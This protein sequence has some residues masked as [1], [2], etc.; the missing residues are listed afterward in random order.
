MICP[1]EGLPASAPKP[2]TNSTVPNLD[3]FIDG[4]LAG[5]WESST[6]ECEPIYNRWL[7]ESSE[8][9]KWGSSSASTIMALLPTLMTLTSVITAD[10]G[11]LCHLSTTQGFIAAAFTFGLP[12]RQQKT[13]KFLKTT[14]VRDLLQVLEFRDDKVLSLRPFSEVADKLLHEI[15]DTALQPELRPRRIWV[16]FLRLSFGYVQAMLIWV[17]LIYVPGIDSFYLI[18]LCPNWGSVVFSLWL[19]TTFTIVG[20]WRARFERNAFKGDEVIYISEINTSISIWKRVLDPHPMILILC[21]SDDLRKDRQH[22]HYFGGMLQL[23]WIGFLSFLFSSTIGGSLFSTLLMVFVFIAVV[24]V[25][26]GLSIVVCCLT[27]KYL[28][29]RVIEY[30]SIE[31]RK[32]IQRLIGGLTGVLLD[33]QCVNYK[34]ETQWD[35]SL[36]MYKWGDQASCGKEMGAPDDNKQCCAHIKPQLRDAFMSSF[37]RVVAVTVLAY[38]V[39]AFP[40]RVMWGEPSELTSVRVQLGAGMIITLASTIS[41]LHLGLRRQWLICKCQDEKLGWPVKVRN[42]L[43]SV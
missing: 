11:L 38:W 40:N 28:D 18:W 12:F 22:T 16:L 31:E 24:G 42:A 25:S 37:Y 9:N 33:I 7:E 8:F 23:F 39:I 20:W 14:K 32:S 5:L 26:R 2:S 3:Q 41:C 30:D 1:V 27:N 36:K 4:P 13:R 21:P 15:R 6:W 17:L 35:E 19:G 29:L 10:I 43:C 34:K